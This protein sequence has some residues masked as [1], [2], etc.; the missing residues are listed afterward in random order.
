M[1]VG[2]LAVS[3]GVASAQK[4]PPKGPKTPAS[5]DLTVAAKPNP[6]VFGKSTVISGKLK[7]G[8]GQVVVLEENPHPY[9]GG[10]KPARTATTA[11]NGDYSFTVVPKLNTRYR[12]S[13]QAAPVTRSAELLVQVQIRVSLRLSDSTPRT[14]SRVRFSGGAAPAH[15]GRTVEIQRLRRGGG[16]GTIARTKLRDAGTTRSKYSRRIRISRTGTFRVRIQGDGDHSTGF[17]SPRTA[18]L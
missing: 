13:T 14:G 5:A 18:R 2:A 4:K 7:N 17:S 3:G 8:G 15:D 6:V 1:L 11:S 9:T 16:Y 12:V 10:F